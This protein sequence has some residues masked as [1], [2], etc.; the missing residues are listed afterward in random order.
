[1]RNGVDTARYTPSAR[2]GGAL[3]NELGVADDRPIIGSVGRL[4]TVKGYEITIAA[5][6]E[7]MATW[8]DGPL[9]ALVLIGDGSQRQALEHA[10][11]A[12]NA[13]PHVHFLGWRSDIERC[14]A[15][16]TIFSMSSHSEGT[17]VSLLEAMSSG[18]CPVVTDV[19]GNAAVLGDALRHRLVEPANPS[20]LAAAWRDALRDESH[21]TSDASAARARV[22]DHFGLDAM[23]RNY[24][25]I[26]ALSAPA[27]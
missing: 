6:G 21:R 17:S 25:D 12:V 2:E 19:G 16:F 4:E 7:L 27:A 24:E 13:T 14:M 10:A 1:V 20:A 26:Y 18:L 15:D 8:T 22:V 3:R 11:A 23:V 9:P 5:F